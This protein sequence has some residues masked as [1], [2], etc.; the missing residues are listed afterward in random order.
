M[1]PGSPA[2]AGGFF[3]TVPLG[4][5]TKHREIIKWK[6]VQWDKPA[7]THKKLVCAHNIPIYTHNNPMCA[8][9]QWGI[10]KGEIQ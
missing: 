8:Y 7:Y 9:N 10:K 5:L 3:T 1:S 4:R 2:L 6:K